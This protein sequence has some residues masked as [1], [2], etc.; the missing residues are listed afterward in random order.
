MTSPPDD[1]ALTKKIAAAHQDPHNREV[2]EQI[3]RQELGHY[4]IWKEY[5]RQDVPPD[6]LRIWFY[7]LIAGAWA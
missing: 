5:T 2:L 3:T 4:E 6:R 1:S 7:Y